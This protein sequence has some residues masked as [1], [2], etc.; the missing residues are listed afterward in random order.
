MHD[1][2]LH[3][4]RGG[5]RLWPV[6]AA[7][8]CVPMFAQQ[9][10]PAPQTAAPSDDRRTEQV[11]KAID[12]APDSLEKKE[13]PVVLSPFTVTSSNDKGYFAANTLAG[14]RMN[15]NL[16]DIGASISV[17]TKQQMDD[18]ASTDINDIFRY[19]VNTE[20]SLTYTPGTQSFRNDGVLDVI[21][22]GTQG[23][24]VAS[25][26]NAQANRVRG[27]GS[28]S[29]AINYYPAI[30]NVPFDSYNTQSVEISRGPNSMLFGLGS[31]AGITNQSTA[32]AQLNRQSAS[33]GFRTDQNGSFRSTLNFNQGLIRD[34]LAIYGAALYDD[35]RF[36][37][38]P[39]FDKTERYYGAMTFKPFK[40]TTI[41]ANFEYYT[42]ENHRPNS[43]TPRD[44][45]TQ[46]N[47]AGQPYYDPTT[48]RIL[49]L[50]TGATLGM[51]VN[52]AQSP[53]AQSL[54][55]YIRGLPNYNPALRGTSATNFNGT[56]TNF[57]FY[58][59]VAIFGNTNWAV[60]AGWRAGTQAPN[61][62]F[63][64]GIGEVN[65][66][67]S[68]MQISNGQLVSWF[69]PT[70][71]YKYL[72]G[73]GTPTNPAANPTP[74]PADAAIYANPTWADVFTRTYTSSAPWTAA[75][76]GIFASSYRYPS[77]TDKSI[78][79][80]T[81][82]NLNSM[83]FGTAS[84]KNYNVEFE[85]ELPWNLFFSSG[86]FRQDYAQRSNYTVAQLNVA[87][88]FVDTN[89]FLPDGSNNPYF[90]KP[91]LEDQDPDSYYNSSLDDHYRA[92]LA[93]T[94]DFT[95]NA[96]WTKWL[97]RHQVL[98]LWSRDEYMSTSI[99]QRLQYISS[100][101]DAGRFRYLRNPNNNADGT[102]TGWNRQ[103]TSLRRTY[104]LA[105]PSDPNGVVTRSAGYWDY[106]SYTGDIRVYDYDQSRFVPVNMT[107]AFDDFDAGTGRNQRLVD[108]ISGGITSYLWNNRVIF[109]YGYREDK[110]KARVTNTGLPAVRDSAGNIIAPAITNAQKWVNGDFQRD[111]LFNRWGPYNE[112]TG[113]TSTVGAVV[114]PFQGW[115][116][117][118]RR[119]ENGSRVWQFVRDFGFSFNKSNNFNPPSS[120]LGDFYGKALAKPVG[121]GKDIGVQFSLFDNKLFARVTYF[122]AS[123]LN[124]NIAAPVVFG[125]LS[126]NIDTTLFRNWARTI[127]LINMGRDPTATTFGDALSATEEATVQAESAKIWKLPYDYYTTLPYSLGATR[128]AEARGLEAEL[129]YN[130]T[131]NW[132]MKFTFGKQD[133][134]YASVLKEF[135]PW[136]D[137]RLAVWRAAKAVDHLL[138]Q[139]RQF[140]TYTTSGGRQVDLTN[141]WSSFGYNSAL[142]PEQANAF[143]NP[144]AN[145]NG[146]VAPQLALDRD[147]QGQ[148]VQGQRKYRWSF[149]TS[150]SFTEGR[151]KGFA[152]GGSQ[153]WEDKAVIGYAGKASGVNL[154]GGVPVLD[155][156][157]VKRPYYDKARTY[158]DLWASYRFN[159][160]SNKVRA[161]VQLNV[162][163]VFENGGLRAVA[164]NYD[165]SPYSFRI[166]D[167]RQFT[168]T[169]TFDF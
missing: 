60:P 35:R 54:R 75:G 92:M 162:A 64:P 45:V 66:A 90:G 8:A 73:F 114:R 2:S 144:E 20:G 59:G 21:A 51:M 79:D 82:V 107:T 48:R 47:L 157:D 95:R 37:R 38:K 100:T 28:P 103:T 30:S 78:Y 31:P 86:W 50:K 99:R 134:K 44:Y 25:L 88:L 111:F 46:W 117:I 109:T 110:Y 131:R 133:T 80:W 42:N 76:N 101:S 116:T 61:V 19:E 16:A 159:V 89:R 93:W 102:P 39:S 150:Y 163:N 36:Q 70:Y 49:S 164:V 154:Y 158:T 108:S 67:R 62:L 149:L 112:L 6:F 167:P 98:G 43:L 165:G 69:Q 77:V 123:N 135:T 91:Y 23:N 58:N 57:T 34:K 139:Y 55:D 3:R 118:D 18:T 113:R 9:V 11:R 138:P 125:R 52:N 169:T 13:E 136:N 141:F 26:T 5:R 94:P 119:A 156:S 12:S 83:N 84:N 29:A 27:L 56:D 33:V 127:A 153:R 68:I 152:V 148:S 17:I 140:A 10:A 126:T 121:E 97:G 129:N 166:I 96:G 40:K 32:S 130:P 105:D 120:A 151:L 145:Y 106:L 63:V 1:V 65:Q 168:L 143:A 7:L 132:T 4:S 161:K 160:W 71:Q 22:G 74:Y 14:S 87:T 104:Y 72:T 137:E 128:N 146:V 85:Q 122:E 155:Y 147:L 24:A 142:F 41:K 81:S 115:N 15:T 53:Y 124:E